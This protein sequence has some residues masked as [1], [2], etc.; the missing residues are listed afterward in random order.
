M[1]HFPPGVSGGN[2]VGDLDTGKKRNCVMCYVSCVRDTWTSSVYSYD[3]MMMRAVS[4]CCGN[5]SF[6]PSVS[7]KM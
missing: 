7:I 4:Y 3:E 1:P 5:V 6:F 2:L